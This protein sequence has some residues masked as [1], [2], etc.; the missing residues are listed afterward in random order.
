MRGGGDY[1]QVGSSESLGWVCLKRLWIRKDPVR[2]R[3]V[4]RRMLI[5]NIQCFHPL[6][7]FL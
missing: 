5:G 7:Y 4:R 1:L 2:R 6:E 3:E